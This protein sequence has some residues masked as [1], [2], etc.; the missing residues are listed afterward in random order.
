MN[1]IECTNV[2]KSYRGKKALDQLSFSIAENT[3]TGL[4][5]RNGAGKTT[6]L[7][8]LVGYTRETSGDVKIFSRRPFNH[9]DVA[10]NSIFIDEHVH[11]PSSISLGEGLKMMEMFY[12][13]WNQELAE[14]LFSYFSFEDTQLHS[15]LSKGMKS[16]YHAILGIAARC[17]LTIFDEP[18]SGMDAAVRKDFYRALLKDYLAHPRTILLSS[19]HLNELEDLL[20]NVLLIDEG[21]K[22]FHM[23]LT[24]LKEWAIGIAGKAPHVDEWTYGKDIFITR[25]RGSEK[26]V[27]VRNEFTEAALQ[28][29]RLSGLEITAVSPHDICVYITKKERGGIDDVFKQS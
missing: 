28:S 9:L 20:E 17:P 4:I 8:I 16:T 24:D 15:Q 6:L 12:E 25:Q 21:K 27:V 19:H 22:C 14:R 13:N 1:V 3:I 26:Y 2:T 5:G 29:A 18:T 23:P 7:R 10:A 11:F